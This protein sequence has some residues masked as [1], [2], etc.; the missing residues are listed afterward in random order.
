MFYGQYVPVLSILLKLEHSSMQCSHLKTFIRKGLHVSI[1]P[2]H[3]FVKLILGS[4]TFWSEV[5]AFFDTKTTPKKSRISSKI[6]RHFTFYPNAYTY[7]RCINTY[8]RYF[9]GVLLFVP[10]L[11]MLL[12]LEHGAWSVH[13]LNHL[14]PRDFMFLSTIGA[15]KYCLS[16]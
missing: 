6:F 14:H 13:T 12:K 11:S 4:T 2:H 8:W 5:I 7:S 1:T 15:C 10:V 9:F 3:N 16:V